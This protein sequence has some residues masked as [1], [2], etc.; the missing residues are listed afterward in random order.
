[1]R[2]FWS[3]L[4]LLSDSVKPIPSEAC[5]SLNTD[6]ESFTEVAGENVT[7]ACLLHRR[8]HGLE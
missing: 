2:F 5:Q 1:M 3:L 7:A 8:E 6:E 4:L